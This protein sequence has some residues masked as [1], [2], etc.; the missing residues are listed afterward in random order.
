VG[1]AL[2]SGTTLVAIGPTHGWLGQS[3]W[4]REIAGREAGAPP[5]VDLVAERAAGEFVRAQIGA[6]RVR[7]CHDVSDGGLLVTVAEMALASGVGAA[8]DPAP[9]AV[10]PH[11]YWFGED[12]GRYVLAVDDAAAMIEAARAAGVP[13]QRIGAAGGTGLTLG[14]TNAIS[15]ETLREA[16]ERFFSEWMR[17]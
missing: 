8:L 13:A 10:A 2:P 17:S 16:H 14:G 4:L 12:Q 15:I 1:L 11:A 7:A 9:D 6:G 5:P 3:L